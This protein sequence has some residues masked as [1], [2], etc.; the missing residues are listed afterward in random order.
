MRTWILALMI[1]LLP[2]RGWVGDAMATPVGG[3]PTTVDCHLHDAAPSS[4]SVEADAT[5]PDAGA[6]HAPCDS[7]QVCHGSAVAPVWPTL[8]L[9]RLAL[10]LPDPRPVSFASAELAQGVK[11]PIL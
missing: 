1:A 11:P 7:C 8:V 10:A 4:D 5:D 2:L 3:T 6:E 9:P